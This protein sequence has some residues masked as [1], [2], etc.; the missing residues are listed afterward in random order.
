MKLLKKTIAIT[1]MMASFS[2]FAAVNVEF[3]VAIEPLLVNGEEVSSL[4]S[5]MTQVELPNGANQLVVRVSKLIRKNGVYTKFK[6]EPVA[7]TLD[8]S[9][10]TVIIEPGKHINSVQ[11]VGDFEKNPTLNILNKA[12]EAVEV[13][14]GILQRGKGL[15]RDYAEELAAYNMD[16]DY[17]FS[18]K[19]K[20]SVASSNSSE[21]EISNTKDEASIVVTEKKRDNNPEKVTIS[22]RE[23]IQVESLKGQFKSLSP[24]EKKEFLRWAI[25]Q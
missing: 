9:D 20:E 16:N 13:H 4:V 21:A 23:T 3:D 6:S 8:A 17:T 5:Q 14:S 22:L 12:G 7:V 19:G 2:S 11:E 25:M 10:T 15:V 18:F 24:T 1:A